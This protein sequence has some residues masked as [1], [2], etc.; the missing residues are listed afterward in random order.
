MVQFS[1]VAY[2]PRLVLWF[3]R[4]PVIS[5]GMGIFTA[6]FIF[7]LSALAWTDRYGSGKVPFV[8]TWVVILLVIA[9][10]L[11]LSL[12]VQRLAVLQV[13]GVIAF[14]G[15]RGRR[16]VEEMYPVAVIADADKKGLEN[17]PPLNLPV[18]QSLL[19]VGG[20]MVIDEY[21]LPA[22]VQLAVAAQGVITLPY[23]VGDSVF[24]GDILA[25]V[26]GG[27]R[28]IPLNMLRQAVQLDRQ[29]SF[30]QDPKYALRLLVDIA[31]RALSPAVNDPT[32]AVQALDEIEDLLR[33]L[34]TRQLEVGRMADSA[35]TLRLIFPTP[36]WEDFLS[37]AFD[38]IRF[39]GATS[40]QVMRRLHT[41]L[42]DLIGVVPPERRNAVRHYIEHLDM[43]VK[44]S[45]LDSEDQ[46]SALRQDRQGL[47]LTR[48]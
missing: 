42:R 28:P 41:A 18:T 47:G 32:T 24:E 48:K 23:A 46:M 20:P 10:V 37:L 26:N 38:E 21:D 43:N 15:I 29:R 8:S 36:I 35:G 25:T 16:A 13:S 22:L 31:I 11:I 3:S 17:S 19:H 34:A 5:H 40:L 14:V 39:Y 30:E 12:M 33:R 7:S 27:D 1:S 9:S 2:S 44:S 6:T 4:D 45:I